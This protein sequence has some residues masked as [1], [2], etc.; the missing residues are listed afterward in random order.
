[1]N[2]F[3][4]YFAHSLRWLI[5]IQSDSLLLFAETI[6]QDRLSEYLSV[7]VCIKGQYA[8]RSPIF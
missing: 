7:T 8:L 4:C 2:E 1:M 3:N 5:Q 6:A